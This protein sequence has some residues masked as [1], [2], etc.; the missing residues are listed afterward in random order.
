MHGLANKELQQSTMNGSAD[1][2][3]AVNGCADAEVD[4]GER[5]RAFF[6]RAAAKRA[7]YAHGAAAETQRRQ[8][9]MAQLGM[10]RAGLDALTQEHQAMATAGGGL[11]A[12]AADGGSPSS[13]SSG[14]G[15]L[16]N[17]S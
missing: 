12:V 4:Y 11:T 1:G 3:D 16:S 6:A 9:I 17:S 8:Q 5:Q 13:V 7:A 14:A 10:D 2:A 15:N